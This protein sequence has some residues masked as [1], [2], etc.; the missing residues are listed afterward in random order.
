MTKLTLAHSPDADDAFM[1]Y[2]LFRGKIDL[3]GL[4]FEEACEGVETLNRKAEES[5]YDV[6][7]IS[8]HAYPSIQE[9]YLILPTGACFGEKYGPVLVS[10]KQLRPRQVL[11]LRCAI[12][13]KR[14]TA[15]LVMK[16]WERTIAGEG[17]SGLSYTEVPFDQVMEKVSAKQMDLGL[18]IHEGQL[19]YAEK[20][21][22]KVVDLG[23]WWHT[24]TALPLP[25]GVVA[26]RKSLGS[27]IQ[28]KIN[29]VIQAS[30]R[31]ALEHKEEAIQYALPFARGL[32]EARAAEF[33]G[34]Y[35]NEM[36]V[37]M[38]R[39]G[40]KAIRVLFDRAFLNG[41]ILHRVDTAEAIFGH[42]KPTE[43]QPEEEVSS[44]PSPDQTILPS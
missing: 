39:R 40:V 18:V 5:A 30:I 15:F 14:T 7:A 23:E 27:E 12:P 34:K 43:T 16:F 20:G 37:S 17:R 42:R 41:L 31:Y 24:Q 11:K 32:D 4:E 2:A 25:L 13:G 29:E 21:L 10:N 9:N 19:T 6:S 8:L 36:T 1:F 28:K 44:S 33:I 38:G 35:V 26:V 22:F 3:Q